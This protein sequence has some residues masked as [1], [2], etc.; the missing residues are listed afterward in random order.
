VRP[1][2]YVATTGHGFG[3]ATR[4]AAVVATIQR[5]RPDVLP[6]M[7]TM[8][9]RWLLASYLEGDFIYRPRCLDVGVIQA[10]SLAIDQAATL[11]Q[12]Q[13]L[14]RRSRSLIA[15]EVDFIRQMSIKNGQVALVLADTPWLAIAIAQGAGVP[16]WLVG[17]FGWDFIYRD[18]GGEFGAIADQISAAYAQSD[19]LFRLPFHEPMAA[20]P[21][22]TDVG[23]TGGAP[24]DSVD[25]LRDRLQLPEVPRDRTVLLT[26]GG[27]GLRQIPYDTLRRFDN[28]LF[29]TFDRQAP[30]DQPNVVKI[31][32]PIEDQA[33]QRGDRPVDLMPL[34]GRV[35][36]K[37]GYSTFAEACRLEV[38]IATL[39]RTGFAE[40]SL[41]LN[42]IQDVA[43]HQILNAQA[44]LAG[45]WS[46]LE[47]PCTPPRTAT[48]L[49]KDGNGAIAQAVVNQLPAPP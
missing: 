42:G 45:D 14:Q 3:H 25:V 47:Q 34:C 12:L 22:I 20:F 32:D 1:I 15:A 37:P 24:R 4:M 23:L 2:L 6:V 43:H 40:A 39:T 17:N 13:D 27:L 30:D 41:L 19:R 8:S 10:D 26:F 44:F 9:P 33:T 11:E 16:C 35:V 28:W 18:W 46:F 21:N 49:A 48:R 7:V 38:P 29:L 5:S 36:S 31:L